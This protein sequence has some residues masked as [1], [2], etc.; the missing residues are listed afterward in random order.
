M[1]IDFHTHV[2]PTEIAEKTISLLSQRSKLKPD[3]DGTVGGLVRSMKK[4]GVD[5]SV[6]LPI[7]TK[8]QQAQTINRYAAEITG[9]NGIISFGSI[10][11]FSESWRRELDYISKLGLKGIKLHPD[12]QNFFINDKKIFPVIEYAAALGLIVLFHSGVDLGIPGYIHCCPKAAGELADALSG[13]KLIFA[14]TGGYECWGE[15][16]EYMAGKNIYFDLSFTLGKLE[17]ELL[18]RIIRAH[19]ADKCLFG[20][21]SPWGSQ[22]HDVKAIKLIG[23]SD[24]ELDAIM[25]KNA[26]K[27][28]GITV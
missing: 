23:L 25:Y 6:V 26:E 10:H 17:N 1:I 11:P 15:V 8:P 4:S 5:Y 27:L 18:M 16:E 9:K 21:D 22:E 14:H 3:T 24:G 2:F 13:A 28:L 19:G 7:A 20:S 12:Y